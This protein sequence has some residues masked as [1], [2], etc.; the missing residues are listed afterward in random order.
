VVTINLPN[1]FLEMANQIR[2]KYN[3]NMGSALSLHQSNYNS[4]VL[5]TICKIC[6][7]NKASETHHL[8]HQVNANKDGIITSNYDDTTLFHKNHPANL[9]T[10]CEKCHKKIHN[11]KKQHVKKKTS[12][13]VILLKI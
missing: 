13:G 1:N 5:I 2:I 10:I 12:N 3:P 11:E 6:N 8:Q 9:L 4:N 7:K